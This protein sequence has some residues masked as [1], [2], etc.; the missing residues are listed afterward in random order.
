MSF[1]Q[2]SGSFTQGFDISG[3]ELNIEAQV[4]L[5]LKEHGLS[6]KG[7]SY[8]PTSDKRRIGVCNYSSK[9]IGISEPL[10]TCVGLDEVKQA[11]IHEVAH[12]LVGSEVGHGKL[13]KETVE[14]LGGVPVVELVIPGVLEVDSW[15]GECNKGHQISMAAAPRRV[16]SCHYCSDSFEVENILHWSKD[17]QPKTPKEIG[18]RYLKEYLQIRSIWA[19]GNKENK[20]LSPN[21]YGLKVIVEGIPLSTEERKL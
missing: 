4:E 14:A 16:R 7:W 18:G 10:S 11:I 13:W 15:R 8:S 1:P 2:F 6:E 20:P 3:M 19:K 21:L 9:T 12:A 5:M 17:G